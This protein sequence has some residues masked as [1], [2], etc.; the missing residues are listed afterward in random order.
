MGK[1]AQILFCFIFCLGATWESS[2]TTP[3]IKW[4]TTEGVKWSTGTDTYDSSKVD[5]PDVGWYRDAITYPIPSSWPQWA[6]ARF[7]QFAHNGMSD[8]DRAFSAIWAAPNLNLST[9]WMDAKADKNVGSIEVKVGQFSYFTFIMTD[10][11]DGIVDQDFQGNAKI[12]GLQDD[13]AYRIMAWDGTGLLGQN[14]TAVSDKYIHALIV[15]PDNLGSGRTPAMAQKVVEDPNKHLWVT[16]YAPIGMGAAYQFVDVYSIKAEGDVRSKFRVPLTTSYIK[17]W[18]TDLLLEENGDAVFTAAETPN[19]PYQGPAFVARIAKDGQTVWQTPLDQTESALAIVKSDRGYIY[20]GCNWD[21]QQDYACLSGITEQIGN[22][23][24]LTVTGAVTIWGSTGVSNISTGYACRG[25]TYD[26][27]QTGVT[28]STYTNLASTMGGVSS[29]TLSTGNVSDCFDDNIATGVQEI[30]IL[31]VNET[32]TWDFGA[33]NAQPVTLMNAY[34]VDARLSGWSTWDL[35]FSDDG[36]TW[37]TFHS[38]GIPAGTEGQWISGTTDVGAKRYWRVRA[39]STAPISIG[40]Y[41]LEL[42][43][44]DNQNAVADFLTVC[45]HRNN[46]GPELTTFYGALCDPHYIAA[47]GTDGYGDD[48]DTSTCI[49]GNVPGPTPGYVAIT[50]PQAVHANH[51]KLWAGLASTLRYWDGSAWQNVGV[52]ASA[53]PGTLDFE[54]GSWIQWSLYFADVFALSVCEIQF[55]EKK[56]RLP[57]VVQ[58]Y[59]APQTSNLDGKERWSTTF[60]SVSGYFTSIVKSPRTGDYYVCGTTNEHDT[61]N[62]SAGKGIVACVSESGVSQWV[63]T[64]TQVSVFYNIA[65]CDDGG[66][67]LAGTLYSG[68]S[69]DARQAVIMK[70]DKNGDVDTKFPQTFKETQ[71][72]GADGRGVIETRDGGALLVGGSS[73]VANTSKPYLIKLD[74][75]YRSC[76]HGDLCE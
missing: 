14:V 7:N 37:T 1:I 33:G 36:A 56:T 52:I 69:V 28:Y 31:I 65:K 72:L 48:N 73:D 17:T 23:S 45:G 13:K 9:V 54:V 15:Q 63:K 21:G 40:I 51:V 41:E 75:F 30:G 5:S 39:N 22:L 8:D 49:I 64:Y 2:P 50:F 44:Y 59:T 26:A 71:A 35:Q 32:L 16:A 68:T 25:A 60:S 34:C 53:S 62:L 42:Y 20:V 66:F 27:S 47:A 18:E 19:G 46:L 38:E 74:R 61:V 76:S 12:Y 6:V 24:R 57:A 55:Y 3:S 70:I 4:S 10:P 58:Y 11:N 67:F 29:T 43:G